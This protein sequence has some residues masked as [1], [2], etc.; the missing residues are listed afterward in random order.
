MFSTSSL[1]DEQVSAIKEWVEDGAQLADIQ[2]RMESD[3]GIRVTYMDTRFL[4]LDLGLEIKSESVSEES[5]DAPQE[6]QETP[7][8]LTEDDLEILPP[9]EAG[10]VSVTIDE[11]ATPGMMAGGKVTF[12]DGE[13]GRWYVDQMGRLGVDPDT[14]GYKPSEADLL[15]FQQE[16]Q[17]AMSKR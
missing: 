3:L 15:A 8:D 6:S 9:K 5:D 12:G 14:P 13:K 11:I 2:K 16:L 4:V 1:S 17:S 7:G 10:A